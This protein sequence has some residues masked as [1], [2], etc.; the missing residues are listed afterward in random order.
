[1]YRYFLAAFGLMLSIATQAQD[2]LRLADAMALGL[3]KNYGVVI[4]RLN[5]A[6]LDNNTAYTWLNW[7]PEFSV[8]GGLN[9]RTQNVNLTFAS[10]ETQNRPGAGT[11]SVNANA[12]L[13]YR[14][15]EGFGKRYRIQLTELAAENGQQ[16]LET[17]MESTLADVSDAYYALV[18]A[19]NQIEV[20]ET[21]LALSRERVDLAQ[22]QYEVGKSSKLEYLQAQV[23][24]NTD[25]ALWL[26]Q[27]EAVQS[28]SISLNV[29]LGQE[30]TTPLIP[31][32]TIPIDT[33]LVFETLRQGL[34][35]NPQIEQ[36]RNS[37]TQAEVASE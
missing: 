30:P 7:M 9:Q 32:S 26:A 20:L 8:D 37:Q 21:N 3:E 11:F 17:L 16:G 1:M 25:S 4:N 33:N 10:G 6:V 28:A 34:L 13:S 22:A 14:L 2:T 12:G 35:E 23:D 31:E 24:Y 5:Q 27:Q 19:N 29:L 36:Q 15:F 18:V